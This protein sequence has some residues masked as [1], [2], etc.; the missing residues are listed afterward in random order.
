MQKAR[1]NFILVKLMWQ[2]DIVELQANL[3]LRS[4]LGNAMSPWAGAVYPW[5]DRCLPHWLA[6]K[7]LG[8]STS[9]ILSPFTSSDKEVKCVSSGFK[10]LLLYLLTG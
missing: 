8:I 10:S 6:A 7:V 9:R 5:H 4:V 1:D 2:R 3:L